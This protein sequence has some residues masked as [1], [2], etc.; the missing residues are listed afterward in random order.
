LLASTCKIDGIEP[1]LQ[2]A[3]YGLQP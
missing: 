3:A 1:S 2:H